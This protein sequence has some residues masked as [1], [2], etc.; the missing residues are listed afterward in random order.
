MAERLGEAVLELS[1]KDQ[2]FTRGVNKAER[3]AKNLDRQFKRVS[4][5]ID[6]MGRSMQG[7][8]KRL[9]IAITA[10]LI[11]IGVAAI[12]SASDMQE[13]RNLTQVTFGESTK[14][15]LKWS[16][17]IG[18]AVG[19]SSVTLEKAATEFGSFLKPLGI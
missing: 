13:L 1:T 8:G 6:R 18:K 5:S 12:K 19:R 15:V 17:E 11:A 9:S 7:L 2:K 16:R 10:P 3:L 14:A 4:K